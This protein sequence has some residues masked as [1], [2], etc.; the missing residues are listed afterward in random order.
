[1]NEQNKDGASWDKLAVIAADQGLQ[2][3]EGEEWKKALDAPA[4]DKNAVRG[5]YNDYDSPG[6]ATGVAL[7]GETVVLSDAELFEAFK[8]DHAQK[9]LLER[10]YLRFGYGDLPNQFAY[11]KYMEG[12]EVAK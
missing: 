4:T 7:D 1:M 11:K 3:V 10:A 6:E 5:M 12:R 2:D 9:G 8:A